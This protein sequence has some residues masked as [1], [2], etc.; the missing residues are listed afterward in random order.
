M[1]EMRELLFELGTEEIPARLLERAR[2]EL[3]ERLGKALDAAGLAHEGLV[4]YA[5]PRRLVV[6]CQVAEKQP[7]RTEEL[8]GPPA[9]VAFDDAGQP[10][11]AA[12]GFAKRNNVP[13]DALERRETPKGEYLG[14]T[15]HTTGQAATMLLGEMLETAVTKL[16]WPKAMRWGTSSDTFIRP[17]HWIV[18]IF[19]GEVLPVSLF[20][21]ASGRT[22]RGHRFLDP[23][24]FEV[25]G[26]DDML[27]GL[28]RRHV[29]PDP[30]VRRDLI[31]TAARELA[32]SVGGEAIVDDALLEEVTGLVE[33]PVPLIGTF[34]EAALALPAQVLITSMNVHQRYFAVR[35]ADGTLSNHFVIIGGMVVADPDVVVA[36]NARVLAARL[37]DAR[38]FYEADAKKGIAHFVPKLAGRR[39]LEGLGTMHD[40]AERLERLAAELTQVLVPEDGE[41]GALAA[42]AGLLCKADLAT[43]MVGEFAKLQGEMGADYARKSGEDDAVATAIE[44]HYLPKH[45]ADA[46]PATAVG[47]AVALAD[48]LD[49]LVG[50]FALG[51]EPTGSADPYALR[52]QALGVLRIIEGAPQAPSLGEALDLARAAYGDTLDIDWHEVRRRLMSFFRGRLKA[53]LG[54][55]YPSDLTEAVL[56]V[57]YDDPAD[58]R[59]RLEALYALKQTQVWETLAAGVKRVANIAGDH[60]G[61]PVDPATLTEPAAVALFEA[62]HTVQHGAHVALDTGAYGEALDRLVTLK[63]TIDRFFDDVLVMSDDD[64]ERTR[65]L[66]LLASIHALFHRIAAFDKVST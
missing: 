34:D 2:T 65:R 18:A 24:P 1:S 29:E 58:A 15:V 22:T 42:R 57:G 11:K 48:R 23:D 17:V 50:C 25:T 56:T 35:R 43:D 5:T 12:I 26:I 55:T 7:D 4:T 46:V 52:R 40:K 30:A 54:Q 53:S 37:A 27:S 60:P 51:L 61:G 49:S 44:E 59:G 36:G 31:A 16:H 62:W 38:F 39:F 63:P 28:R 13:V 6:S 20:G 9:R 8:L 3:G 10:T 41:A 66:S 64:E 19:A 45:A 14:C 32:S 21:I 33:W 47:S